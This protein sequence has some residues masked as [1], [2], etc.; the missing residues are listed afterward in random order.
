M[1]V[2]TLLLLRHGQSEWNATN[3]F[4][5]WVDVGLTDTGRAEAVRAGELLR[6]HD[7]L[8]DLVHTSVLRRATATAELTLDVADRHW[9]PVR[10][11]WRLNERHYGD[12]QGKDKA[13]I[14]KEYGDEQFMAWRRS[15]DTPPPPI[16]DDAEFSQSGD[17]KYAALAPEIVPRTECLA[18]VV[19]RL[20]PY[21]YDAVVPDLR[22]DATVLVVAHGNSLRA[23]VKH[24]DHV[25]PQTI[26]GL[27]IPTGIPLRYDLD[28][29][30]RPVAAGGTYLDPEAATDAIEAVRNQGR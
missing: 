4:T 6:E 24:L 10:R 11:S 20:L 13:A 1:S 5:G 12:L 21:W 25:D 7:L 17:A 3:Q 19:E 26:V 8:P 30:L 9:I 14:R 15:Y 22:A 28:D 2:G 16:A 18:D 27:N 29:A 23:L